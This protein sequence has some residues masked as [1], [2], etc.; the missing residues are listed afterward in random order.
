MNELFNEIMDSILAVRYRATRP[1]DCDSASDGLEAKCTE[2][3]FS[4]VK[5]HKQRPDVVTMDL[6]T[7]A[8]RINNEIKQRYSISAD[9]F[10][11]LEAI[12]QRIRIASLVS[13]APPPIETN[14]QKDD[15]EKNPKKKVRKRGMTV[16]AA[17]CVRRYKK[18]KGYSKMNA[19]VD[20]YAA[21]QG[22]SAT[23]IMR[24]LNDNPNAWKDDQ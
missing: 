2:L 16:E 6:L 18:A 19:I 9:Q 3:T 17:D 23:S 12:Y 1:E 24:V 13:S 21:E 5:G 8:E 20:E 10:A 15:T 7:E 14:D 11:G 22:K 4:L